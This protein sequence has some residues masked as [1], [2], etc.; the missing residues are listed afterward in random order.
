MANSSLSEEQVS[1]GSICRQYFLF[2]LFCVL[3]VFVFFFSTCFFFFLL[4]SLF[5]VVFLCFMFVSVFD[6]GPLSLSAGEQAAGPHG[7]LH[8]EGGTRKGL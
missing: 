4:L 1:G 2:C 6:W 3:C 5:L 7:G 8:S